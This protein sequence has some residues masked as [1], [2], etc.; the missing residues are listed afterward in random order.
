MVAPIATSNRSTRIGSSSVVV[1]KIDAETQTDVEAELVKTEMAIQTD[2]VQVF[3]VDIPLVIDRGP[4]ER[5]D[6]AIQTEDVQIYDIDA[7][8][9]LDSKTINFDVETQTEQFKSYDAGVQTDDE[10]MVELYEKIVQTDEVEFVV[11]VAKD[12][13]CVQTEPSSTTSVQVQTDEFEHKFALPHYATTNS[14]VEI[15][16]SESTVT[17]WT[18]DRVPVGS[19]A[20][21]KPLSKQRSLVSDANKEFSSIDPDNMGHPG[22]DLN[23]K[24]VSL[25][26]EFDDHLDPLNDVSLDESKSH[27]RFNASISDRVGLAGGL[28]QTIEQDPSNQ[29]Y[30]QAEIQCDDD[31]QFSLEE[32]NSQC[33][34]AHTEKVDATYEGDTRNE[35][36]LDEDDVVGAMNS[37]PTDTRNHLE[38]EDDESKSSDEESD[39]YEE[40]SLD[41][42]TPGSKSSFPVE[43]FDDY[44]DELQ[45]DSP[46]EDGDTIFP[47]QTI[48]TEKHYDSHGNHHNGS[49][50]EES[51]K[52]VHHTNVIHE[53]NRVLREDSAEDQDIELPNHVVTS[54]HNDN[55][56]DNKDDRSKDSF[57]E[58]NN[59]LSPADVPG[60]SD[61]PV[62]TTTDR[63]RNLV[64]LDKYGQQNVDR[65][66]SPTSRFMPESSNRSASNRFM[67]NEDA[68]KAASRSSRRF[69]LDDDRLTPNSTSRRNPSIPLL[70]SSTAFSKGTDEGAGYDEL[71]QRWGLTDDEIAADAA[72]LR[73]DVHFDLDIDNELDV[74]EEASQ[75]EEGVPS[76]SNSLDGQERDLFDSDFNERRSSHGPDTLFGYK[77]DVV[78]AARELK[79]MEDGESDEDQNDE[80]PSS[81]PNDDFEAMMDETA[82]ALAA[83]D[84]LI[85]IVDD[86]DD[87]GGTFANDDDYG[88]EE[89]DYE[90]EISD[91]SDDYIS[92][93]RESNDE[94]EDEFRSAQDRRFTRKGE[95]EKEQGASHHDPSI[96]IPEEARDEIRELGNSQVNTFVGNQ[97]GTKY[98]IN[99]EGSMTSPSKEKPEKYPNAA[100][101]SHAEMAPVSVGSSNASP[102][103]SN[104]STRG[105]RDEK[106]K[107]SKRSSKS[108]HR[109]PRREGESNHPRSQRNIHEDGERERRRHHQKSS[110][111]VAETEEESDRRQRSSRRVVEGDEGGRSHRQVSSRRLTADNGDSGAERRR[112]GSSRRVAD[113]A[114]VGES[115]D[116]RRSSRNLQ[117]SGEFGESRRHHKS[118]SRGGSGDVRESRRRRSGSNLV[119]SD[120]VG[121]SRHH[122][123]S[124]RRDGGDEREEGAERRRSSRRRVEGDE[125][126]DGSDRRRRKSRRADGDE[127]EEGGERHRRSSRRA[128]GD[129][130]EGGGER[131]HRSSRRA[132]GDVVE[133]VEGGGQRHKS[134]RHISIEEEG[135]GDARPRR[136]RRTIPDK[137]D[138]TVGRPNVG[139]EIGDDRKAS[140]SRRRSTGDDAKVSKEQ[141]HRA[142]EERR[143]RKKSSGEHWSS[144]K[145]SSR[146]GE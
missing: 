138:D 105:H 88:K 14:I 18:P 58:N 132:S 64:P 57:N 44:S 92:D 91:D 101:P 103:T 43:D 66:K 130:V 121:E 109:S 7:P 42:A 106:K 40:Q 120:G 23:L 81:T 39:A 82:A 1:E 69:K 111:H 34:D 139:A 9:V 53:S 63:S 28:S 27:D 107:R 54:K 113:S 2:D 95:N 115:R 12:D 117:D 31:D 145:S 118:S 131:R 50:Y 135:A 70:P 123:R 46:N 33:S 37:L 38:C 96:W 98:P 32:T 137:G 144:R 134:S 122:H 86:D 75:D 143:R 59:G 93:E 19:G 94:S 84:A 29:E 60:H 25:G 110:R 16:L 142:D 146:L 76:S 73:Q 13:A 116:R 45:H 136:S 87:D 80:V 55:L 15:P 56:V 35:Q 36:L 127:G 124:R 77:E 67:P 65:S 61:T 4:P 133:D 22:D 52:G 119:D 20:G 104:Q 10:P 8:M 11:Q 125:L 114:D 112:H 74:I 129:V 140:S 21:S 100:N 68:S 24:Q 62:I 141:E 85:G 26:N 126:E 41:I 51:Q 79:A 30:D 71:G 47:Q 108:P 17:T 89:N 102:L 6:E 128:S 72:V 3:D 5:F 48:I 97:E 90:A 83:A 99:D 78:G 49:K